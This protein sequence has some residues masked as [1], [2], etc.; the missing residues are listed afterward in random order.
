[1][2]IYIGAPPTQIEELGWDV[3]RDTSIEMGRTNRTM[4]TGGLQDW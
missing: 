3:M 4:W 2:Q 1:M